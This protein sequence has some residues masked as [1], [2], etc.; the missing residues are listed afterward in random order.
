MKQENY[1]VV[2]IGS[3]IGGMCAAALLSHD[4]YRTLVV[5]KMALLGGRFSTLDHDGFKVTTG[6]IMFPT[7]GP[8]AEVFHEVGA[9]YEIVIPKTQFTFRFDGTDYDMPDR[10]ILGQAISIAGETKEEVARVMGA[11]RKGL[12]WEEPSDLIS[13]REWLLQYTAND[14]ILGIFQ[15]WVS[16]MHSINAYEMPAGEYFRYL[17]EMG[18]LRSSGFPV[19]GSNLNLIRSLA[20]VVESKGGAV[21]VRCRAKRILVENEVVQGLVF[22]NEDHELVEARAKVIISNIGPSG[23]VELAGAAS[24]DKGYLKELSENLKPAPIIAA[25]TISDRPLIEAPGMLMLPQTRRV[26]CFI[27]PTLTCPEMAPEGKH[28][29]E[30]FGAIKNSLTPVNM[31]EEIDLHIQDLKDNL[32]GLDENAKI[33]SINCFQGKWPTLRNWPGAALSHKTSVEN[34]YNVGDGVLPQGWST[35]SGCAKTAQMVAEDVKNRVVPG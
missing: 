15:S 3:G 20:E 10:G 25:H 7:N 33:L 6:A 29:L 16:S 9:K 27:C 30:S 12:K 4:G 24:F 1:D 26:S 31:K 23:T 21:L 28:I 2:V 18:S 8:L 17:K 32:P 14:K 22:E 13:L 5:E 35:A 11:V 34:L 19:D